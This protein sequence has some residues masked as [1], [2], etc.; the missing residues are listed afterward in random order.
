[1]VGSKR[2]MGG[3]TTAMAIREEGDGCAGDVR[4]RLVALSA[5]VVCLSSSFIEINIC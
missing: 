1:M 5:F 2:E 3:H 4:V